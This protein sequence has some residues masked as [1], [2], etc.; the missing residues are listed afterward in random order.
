MNAIGTQLRDSIINSG[1]TRWRSMYVC[2][3]VWLS[4]AKIAEYRSPGWVR[5]TI[6]LVVSSTGKKIS[7]SPFAPE[8]RFRETGLA[9][10]SRVRLL[11]LHTQVKG[12]LPISAAASIHLYIYIYTA[13]RHRVS[14]EFIEPRN[15]VPMRREF[16]GTGPGVLKVVPVT[17]G[18]AFAGHHGPIIV[19]CASRS[20]QP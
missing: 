4:H 10:P 5:L 1:L 17:T 19:M 16:A 13:I 3:Y 7:L 20:P 18:A 6:L 14:T 15:C 9:V 12:F 8:S 11:T 2:M